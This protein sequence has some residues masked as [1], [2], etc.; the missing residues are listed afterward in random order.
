MKKLLLSLLLAFASMQAVPCWYSKTSYADHIYS[1][2]GQVVHSETKIGDVTEYT[3]NNNIV[4]DLPLT[5]TVKLVSD[6]EIEIGDHGTSIAGEIS[7]SSLQYRVLPNGNW[8]TVCN[9]NSPLGTISKDSEPKAYFGTNNI[10]PKD[11]KPGD[12][13]MIRVYVTDGMWQSGYLESDISDKLITVSTKF[14]QKLSISNRFT[15]LMDGHELLSYDL[16]GGWM[17]HLVTTVVYS[18]NERPTK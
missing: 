8:V 2:N 15:Y 3:H 18:G 4:V 14:G 11:L 17:P 12:V 9:Y 10:W 7:R 16:G 1:I 13:I 5:V 6:Q